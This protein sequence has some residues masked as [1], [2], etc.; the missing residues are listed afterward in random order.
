MSLLDGLS[1]PE[2]R[3]LKRLLRK[4]DRRAPPSSSRQS[5]DTRFRDGCGIWAQQPSPRNARTAGRRRRRCVSASAWYA[6][7]PG[8]AAASRFARYAGTG[9]ALRNGATPATC[10]FEILPVAEESARA[11]L[12]GGPS[13][14]TDRAS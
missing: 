1:E 4:L 12:V 10:S 9:P 6:G 7:I 5:S 14:P 8:R 3:Q 2:Q 13:E 11:E